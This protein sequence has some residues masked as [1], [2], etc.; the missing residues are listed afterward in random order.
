MSSGRLDPLLRVAFRAVGLLPERVRVVLTGIR[1]PAY[2]LG[3][4]C[5]IVDDAGRW[6]LVRHTY[7]RGWSLPGGGSARGESP[8]D[9]ARREMREELG[10]EIEVGPSAA[11]VDPHIHRLTFAFVAR[12]VSGEPEVRSPE[13]ERFA[14]F[15]PDHLPSDA[16]RWLRL[17]SGVAH[18]LV[19]GEQVPVVVAPKD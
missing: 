2:R 1:T 5:V 3:A 7:R 8:A 9:T 10:I 15:D 6:L 18:R 12:I 19:D 4:S 14:W 11:V 17:A 16:D 13:L